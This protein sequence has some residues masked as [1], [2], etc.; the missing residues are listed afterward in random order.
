M[1]AFACFSKNLDSQTKIRIFKAYY[2]KH[3]GVSKYCIAAITRKACR[4]KFST[5]F[6]KKR[7]EFCRKRT[8]EVLTNVQTVNN[9]NIVTDSIVNS[10]NN[11]TQSIACPLFCPTCSPQASLS[12]PENFPMKERLA[13][14]LSIV[15]SLCDYNSG[16]YTPKRNSKSFEFCLYCM[17]LI[18]GECIA[19]DHVA[20]DIPFKKNLQ[21]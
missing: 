18:L 12:L 13:S 8:I 4:V 9:V 2:Q 16:F 14:D 15:Y 7:R 3:R 20:D 17:K 5:K 6:Y 19:W 10:T 1:H 11:D 21:H